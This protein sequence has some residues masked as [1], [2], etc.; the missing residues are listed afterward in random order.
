[1]SLVQSYL[2]PEQ[3]PG[4]LWQEVSQQVRQLRDALQQQNRSRL[5]D[6]LSTLPSLAARLESLAR[7]GDEATGFAT[8]LGE[9]TAYV[10]TIRNELNICRQL[11][12]D[13]LAVIRW[14]LRLLGSLRSPVTPQEAES[15]PVYRLDLRV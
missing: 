2:Q 13:E 9:A 10:R 4:H 8:G 6:L 11:I 3:Q 14:E 5:H 1:M 15:A 12:A 7:Q